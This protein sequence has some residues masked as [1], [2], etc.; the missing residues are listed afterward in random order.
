MKN[1]NENLI[2][3]CFYINLPARIDKNKDIEEHL[4]G[5]NIL[6]EFERKD[7]IC[8]SA[9]G[10]KRSSG[11]GKFQHVEYSIACARAHLNIIEEAAIKK[12]KYILIL[13]DDA[14][15]YEDK[16]YNGWE[17]AMSA[18]TQILKIKNWDILYIGC[19]IG[20]KELNKVD[21]N[22]LSVKQASSSHAYI[23]NSNSFD[24]LLELKN[25][26]THLDTH[27]SFLFDKKYASFPLTTVQKHINKTDIMETGITM[28]TS[29]WQKTFDKPIAE[30]KI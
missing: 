19:D 30:Q 18:F 22:L 25:E 15:F 11:T 1:I 28:E 9:L 27:M 3:S 21:K 5:L 24:K 16:L 20:D 4:R 26:I 29:F 17:N 7:G 12:L 14:R 13:E 8:P 2:N 6:S 10:Y 23:L